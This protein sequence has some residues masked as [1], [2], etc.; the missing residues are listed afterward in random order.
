MD[1]H[2]VAARCYGFLLISIKLKVCCAINLEVITSTN[3]EANAV[4]FY[5]KENKAAGII[6][7]PACC[8]KDRGRCC[9]LGFFRR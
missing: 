6:L 1:I 8:A 5:N 4:A 2:F 3:S 9:Q 7:A